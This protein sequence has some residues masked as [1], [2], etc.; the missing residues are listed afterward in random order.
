VFVRPT[1]PILFDYRVGFFYFM[2][3][4]LWVG[5]SLSSLWD[6]LLFEVCRGF[7]FFFCLDTKETKNQ[8]QPDGSARL[9]GQRSAL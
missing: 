6:W 8:G 9:P 4:R 3:F 5:V 7:F 2:D 1:P